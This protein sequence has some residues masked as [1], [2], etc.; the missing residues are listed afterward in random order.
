MNAMILEVRA[1]WTQIAS[2]QM[3]LSSVSANQDLWAMDC[4]AKEV[5]LRLKYP[6]TIPFVQTAGHVLTELYYISV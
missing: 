3:V 1:T 6:W 4:V 5:G 2:T